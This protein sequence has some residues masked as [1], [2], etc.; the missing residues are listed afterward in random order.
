MFCFYLDIRLPAHRIAL[1]RALTGTHDFAIERGK[2]VGLARQWRLCRMCHDDVEDVI[3]V[4]F[5]CNR[6]SAVQLRESF[7]STTLSKFPALMGLDSPESLF[8][9]L[10]E[11]KDL[12]EP[13][14]RFVFN[15]F[16]LWK[17]VP[18]F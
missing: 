13:T 4:L 7:L 6:D 11:S 16:S 18:L 14:A 1:T 10:I 9:R 8:H 5:M 15:M 12:V 3:H 2:W 17:S